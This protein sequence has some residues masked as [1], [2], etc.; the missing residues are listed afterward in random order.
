MGMIKAI[1]SGKEHRKQYIGSKVFDKTCRNHGGC[2]WCL[3][4][5]TYKYQ[6]ELN[7]MLDKAKDM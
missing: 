3:Q 2:A 4:N 6:K 7:K 1:A 5:R